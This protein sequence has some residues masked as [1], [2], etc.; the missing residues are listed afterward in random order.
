M[1]ILINFVKDKNKLEQI[2]VSIKC[3]ICGIVK[4][5]DSFL[6]PKEK[7]ILKFI[8]NYQEENCLSPSFREIMKGVNLNSTSNVDRYLY[9]LEK[10]SF[11]YL[12]LGKHRSIKIIKEIQ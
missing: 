7:E 5:I 6:T 2:M 10:K 1:S 11:I 8:K 12:E 3:N 9:K 4:E